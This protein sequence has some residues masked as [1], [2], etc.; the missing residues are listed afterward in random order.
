MLFR[1]PALS[2]T[3][4]LLAASVADTLTIFL[5]AV[6]LVGIGQA[7]YAAVDLALCVGVLPDQRNSARYMGVMGIA[8][9]LPQSLA[10]AMAPLLLAIGTGQN[11]TAMFL[12]AALFGLF[13]AATVVP[14]RKVR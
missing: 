8:S 4:G 12:C 13:G 10:P 14:I 2:L 11:F 7:V 3:A 1:S 9:S 5:V 6:V